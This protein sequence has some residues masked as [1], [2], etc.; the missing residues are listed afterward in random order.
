MARQ[1]WVLRHADAEPH[2]TRADSARR[3]TQRGEAQAS[4]AGEA[5]ARLQVRFDAVLFSPKARARQTAEL[6]AES[7][8]AEERAKLRE[9]EPLAASFEA[10]QALDALAGLDADARLLLIGHEPDLSGVIADLTGA[11]VELKKGGLAVVKLEGVGGELAVLLRPREL[12]L[13]AGVPSYRD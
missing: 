2:G 8:P 10:T 9:H 6:A 3:L 12:A 1:L 5:L 4:T 13:I 11:R 7:W